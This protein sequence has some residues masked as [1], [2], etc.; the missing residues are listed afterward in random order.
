MME[1]HNRRPPDLSPTSELPPLGGPRASYLLSFSTDSPLYGSPEPISSSP[2]V[3]ASKLTP[4][5]PNLADIIASC[6]FPIPHEQSSKGG[7]GLDLIRDRLSVESFAGRDLLHRARERFLIYQQ[8]MQDLSSARGTAVEVRRDW[9]NPLDNRPYLGDPDLLREV[10]RID[11]EQRAERL[12][13]WR[14]LNDLRSKLPEQWARYLSSYRRHA[15]LSKAGPSDH[16]QTTRHV[17][18]AITEGNPLTQ[19]LANPGVRR[20][21]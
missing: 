20:D 3:A 10:Q 6:R 12:S 7:D 19:Y 17:Q 1:Q 5:E 2:P 21:T 11:G 16:P 13:L 14:D 4:S 15:M 9:R 8:H 18:A